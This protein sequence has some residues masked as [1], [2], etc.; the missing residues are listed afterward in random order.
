MCPNFDGTSAEISDLVLLLVLYSQDP[1]LPLGFK[2]FCKSWGYIHHNNRI[3]EFSIFML[4]QVE[5]IS[6]TNS[7]H[8]LEERHK[9]QIPNW[10]RGRGLGGWVCGS[11]NKIDHI[12]G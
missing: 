1:F 3:K 5:M 8:I 7:D 6:F 10:D 12:I 4:K 11:N 9:D 2:I